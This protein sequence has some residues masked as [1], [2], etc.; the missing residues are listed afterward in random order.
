MTSFRPRL[1][2]IHEGCNHEKR[3][4]IQK[5]VAMKLGQTGVILPL[6]Q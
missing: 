6:V 1:Q 4:H 3:F 5:K 2:L